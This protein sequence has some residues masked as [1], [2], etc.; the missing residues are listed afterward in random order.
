[1]YVCRWVEAWGVYK[2]IIHIVHK[3]HRKS[4]LQKMSKLSFHDSTTDLGFREN[5]QD[6]RFL[7]HSFDAEITFIIILPP[8]RQQSGPYSRKETA[9]SWPLD[10]EDARGLSG[11]V[12]PIFVLNSGNYPLCWYSVTISSTAMSVLV[13]SLSIALTT[14][15]TDVP[16]CSV[17][18]ARTHCTFARRIECHFEVFFCCDYQGTM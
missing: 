14:S 13:V 5:S 10:I 18:M 2:R 3:Y 17:P 6:M 7:R 8:I 16:Q 9:A 1:M 15:T 11:I 4:V 12:T